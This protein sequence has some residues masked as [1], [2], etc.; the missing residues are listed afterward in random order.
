MLDGWKGGLVPALGR[1]ERIGVIDRKTTELAY[2]RSANTLRS[3]SLTPKGSYP[4]SVPRFA[5]RA[6]RRRRR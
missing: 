2:V 4:R 6:T 5:R 1:I 3:G